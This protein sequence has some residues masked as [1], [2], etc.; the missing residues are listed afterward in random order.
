VQSMGQDMDIG[1]APFD[2]LAIH[3]DFAV[4]IIIA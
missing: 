3:P 1:V 4:T 2:E